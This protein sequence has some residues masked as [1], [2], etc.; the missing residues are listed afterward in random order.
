MEQ[1]EEQNEKSHKIFKYK[2]NSEIWF[3]LNCILFAI[4]WITTITLTAIDNDSYKTIIIGLISYL[5]VA[6]LLAPVLWYWYLDPPIPPY[7]K[8]ETK[9]NI[10]GVFI[11]HLILWLLLFG[12]AYLYFTHANIMAI[13]A[14]S[15]SFGILAFFIYPLSLMFSG[16]ITD[17]WLYT[18]VNWLFIKR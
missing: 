3:I 8:N 17:G 14:T 11:S 4:G 1:D 12:N 15:G 16:I 9:I 6:T 2:L 5:G 10:F 18:F 13:A 7:M